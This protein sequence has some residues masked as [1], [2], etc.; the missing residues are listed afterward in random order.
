MKPTDGRYQTATQVKVFS[1]EIINVREVDSVHLL[2]DSMIHLD[3][4]RDVLLSRGLRPWYGIAWKLQE[5][6]RAC[7]FLTCSQKV[8][9]NLKKI[10]CSDDNQAVGLTHSRE[11]ADVMVSGSGTVGTLEGVSNITQR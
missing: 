1:P 9:N 10:G 2:E 6:G 3:K 8:A 7:L 4:V 11:V 5:L